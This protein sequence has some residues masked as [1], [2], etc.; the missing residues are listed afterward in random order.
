MPEK[1]DLPDLKEGMRNNCKPALLPFTDFPEYVLLII[2][3]SFSSFSDLK[4][5]FAELKD[6]VARVVIEMYNVGIQVT[7]ENDQRNGFVFIC[8]AA[9]GDF[10][11]S[12]K[13]I[14]GGRSDEWRTFTNR[15]GNFIIEAARAL[16]EFLVHVDEET[17]IHKLELSID[18]ETDEKGKLVKAEEIWY[19]YRFVKYN[20]LMQLELSCL[21]KL[22]PLKINKIC[23]ECRGKWESRYDVWSLL[24][25]VKLVGGKKL[26]FSASESRRNKRTELILDRLF[27]MPDNIKPERVFAAYQF[28]TKV[29]AEQWAKFKEIRMT[30]KELSVDSVTAL[31]QVSSDDSLI[32]ITFKITL[33]ICRSYKRSGPL[34]P[35]LSPEAVQM[36]L[37]NF[38]IIFFRQPIV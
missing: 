6:S 36:I 8:K 35:R 27:V 30:C 29:D 18:R 2:I 5:R 28:W 12:F 4:L 22:R 10:P 34:D 37:E 7:A 21:M 17:V 19:D 23:I 26:F 11:A 31:V 24:P 38:E 3:T 15:P 13:L 16:C 1:S 32:V 20:F 33:S 25:Y 9:P 14:N